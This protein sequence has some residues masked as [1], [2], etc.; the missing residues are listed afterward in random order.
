M[1][2]DRRQLEEILQKLGNG[3]LQPTTLCVVG[4]APA[5]LLGQPSRQ[6]RHLDVWHTQSSY[7]AGELARACKDIGVLYDPRGELD[8][9]AVYIQIVRPGIVALP[10]AFE[11][12]TIGRYGRL[13]VVMPAPVALS[14]AK[15]VRGNANDVNDVVWWV[16]Q[17]SISFRQLEQ[18]INQLPNQR[19]REVARENLVFIQLVTG[20]SS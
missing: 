1:A 8:P 16:Q 7:D 14:A 9:E 10:S 13:T 20:K 15:L 5:V 19:H 3:L 11:T 17:R 2:L 4:S 18:S 6:T 12:E